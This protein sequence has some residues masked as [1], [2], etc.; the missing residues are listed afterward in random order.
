MSCLPK[1]LP[2][3]IEV[4]LGGLN[5]GDSLHMSAIRLPSGV[6]LLAHV[7]EAD[8]DHVVASIQEMRSVESEDSETGEDA[9]GGA[10]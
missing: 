8:H 1:D 10:S 4:D 5:V 3:F 6:S 9:E 2:E 7:E